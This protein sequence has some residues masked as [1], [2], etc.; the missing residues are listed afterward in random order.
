MKDFKFEKSSEEQDALLLLKHQ[1]KKLAKQQ[2]IFAAVFLTGL[3]FLI[4]YIVSRSV[5]TYYDGYISLDKND[6]RAVEDIYILNMQANVGDSV[7]KGDTLF[8]YVIIDHLGDLNNISTEPPFMQ[9]ANDMKTQAMLARQ[10]IP[11]LKEQL[12]QLQLQLKSERNDIFYGLT[13]NTKQNDLK[14]QIAETQAKIREAENKVRIYVQRE[15]DSRL[16]LIRAGLESKKVNAMPY[17]PWGNNYTD[18]FLNYACA[19]EDGFI[20]NINFTNNAVAIKGEN[21]LTMKYR[22][23][24]KSHFHVMVYVPV[25]KA[26]DLLRADSIEVMVDN[27]TR[28]NARLVRMGLGV[29]RLPDYLMNNFS[30]DAMVIMAALE[31]YKGQKIPYWVLNDQLPVKIRVSTLVGRKKLKDVEQSYKVKDAPPS[32]RKGDIPLNDFEER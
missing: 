19:P 7:Q 16:Q 18:E 24:D 26:R 21:I 5:Y 4:L 2:V 15:G 13:N 11:V 31:V 17:S 22:N 27:R 23:I 20:T 6:I 25:D 10:E 8:S 1:H 9:R 28:F 12:R 30:R 32:Q 3:I 29:E 14:A